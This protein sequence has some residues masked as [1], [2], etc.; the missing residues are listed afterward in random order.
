MMNKQRIPWLTVCAA[1]L[2]AFSGLMSGCTD[3]KAPDAS[4]SPGQ[5]QTNPQG[6]GLANETP[7]VPP[8]S[9]QEEASNENDPGR[10]GKPDDQAAA[11]DADVERVIQSID[12]GNGYHKKIELL[13]DGGKRVTI[14]DPNGKATVRKIE[15]EGTISSVSGSEVTVQLEHGGEKT[16]EIPQN[17]IVDD[18]TGQG[19]KI[20][21]EIEWVVD[22]DGTIRKV[23]LDD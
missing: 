23:Q 11:E 5:D 6:G 21:T 3:G 7:A 16:I 8:P 2:I 4:L 9:G 10:S 13:K 17:I 12:T 22:P 1:L 15:Y 18:E 20:G 14:T 19:F